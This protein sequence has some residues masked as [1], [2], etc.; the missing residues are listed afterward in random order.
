[1]DKIDNE[2]IKMY[3]KAK[4]YFIKNNNLDID[5]IS[6]NKEEKELFNWLLE[7]YVKYR[8]YDINPY[9]VELLEM[10]DFKWDKLYVPDI[11]KISL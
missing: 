5:K 8:N 2:W 4:Q 1:M 6:T 9:K 7:Q 11:P 10:L 3:G